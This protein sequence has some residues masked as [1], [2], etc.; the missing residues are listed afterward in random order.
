MHPKYYHLS[1]SAS[2]VEPE[3]IWDQEFRNTYPC[4][5]RHTDQVMDVRIGGSVPNIP[6]NALGGACAIAIVRADLL[7]ELGGLQSTDF[8]VGN[9]FDRLGSVIAG[10]R[11]VG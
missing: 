4:L 8:Q 1:T 2:L 3:K 6:L 9:V 10:F 7:D 5:H 11:T